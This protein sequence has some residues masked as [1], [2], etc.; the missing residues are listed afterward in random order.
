ML[1]RSPI[2]LAAAIRD[3][4]R[5]LGWDQSELARKIGA[6][7]HWVV[8][9]EKGNPGAQLGHILRALN[10]LQLGVSL[11]PLTDPREDARSGDPRINAVVERAR[12]PLRR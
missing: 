10:A 2:A 9:A 4:R 11:A 1:I 12:G 5:S 8:A 6:G 3:R 7:R